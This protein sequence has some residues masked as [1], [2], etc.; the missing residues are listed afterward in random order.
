MAPC[1]FCHQINNC[2]ITFMPIND[3]V[4]DVILILSPLFLVLFAVEMVPSQIS[5]K[6]ARKA[7]TLGH[8][9]L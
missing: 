2:T 1:L 8:L 4:Y 6:Q 3:I 5:L 7:T 9:Y